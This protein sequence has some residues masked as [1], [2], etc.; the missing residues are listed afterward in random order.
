MVEGAHKVLVRFARDKT[1][2]TD[3]QSVL[4]AGV[5]GRATKRAGSAAGLFGQVPAAR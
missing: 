1:T 3:D 2:G 5:S 4:H